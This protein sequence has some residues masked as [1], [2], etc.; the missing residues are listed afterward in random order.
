VARKNE[1]HSLGISIG[2]FRLAAKSPSRPS[3]GLLRSTYDGTLAGAFLSRHEASTGDEKMVD[4]RASSHE[5][6]NLFQ[7]NPVIGVFENHA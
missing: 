6:E 2:G 5:F 7:G 4:L 3:F 1:F